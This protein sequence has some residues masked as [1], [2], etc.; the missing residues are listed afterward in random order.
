LAILQKEPFLVEV[1]KVLKID[2]VEE[3]SC[4]LI[5]KSEGKLTSYKIGLIA[6][7]SYP[8]YYKVNQIDEIPA[9]EGEL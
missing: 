8:F 5:L 6:N 3:K 2:S 1:D 9:T 4:R 7:N